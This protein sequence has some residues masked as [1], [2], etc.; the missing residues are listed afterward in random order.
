MES[1]VSA[2]VQSLLKEIQQV[3]GSAGQRLPVHTVFLGGGTPSLL[4]LAEIERILATLEKMFDLQVEAELTLE[5]NP[6]TVTPDYL[7]GL[8]SLGIN[9][10]S[11]G[12]QSAQPE[13]LRL[14]GRLH[15]HLEVIEAV[16]WARQAGFENVSIDLI[17]GLPGQTLESWQWTVERALELRPEH[18]S[19][20]ALTVEEGTPLYDW[21]SHG[22][23]SSPEDDL[24]ATQYEWASQRLE[25]AGFTC[26]E[27]SNFARRVKHDQ[28]L[29]CR[30]NLQYWIN[31]PYLGFG[32]GA[33][34]YIAGNRL[35]NVSD[36]MEYIRRCQNGQSTN[37]PTGP[38]TA[39]VISIDQRMEMQ[40]T[41]MVRLRLTQ[42]GVSRSTF[43]TRFGIGLE[44]VFGE[45]ILYLLKVDLLEW[46][47][48]ARDH[49]RLTRRGRLLGNQVF[50]RFVGD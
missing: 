49:L 8:H 44:D 25:E 3:A 4:P 46:G 35:A 22:L 27:I 2:Y 48:E 37:F 47:G 31:A 1:W 32:A 33:H 36:L 18:L 29:A 43:Q 10:L 28:L 16:K 38:A 20:Y 13:E 9:R 34:G 24:A 12:M 21:I 14:L 30:H 5:A 23:V 7:R 11:F 40:E 15:G 6:G 45:E 39:Q 19:L 42:E 26:Y 17:Y 41:M 50:M